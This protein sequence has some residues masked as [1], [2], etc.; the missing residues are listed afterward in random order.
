[1][2]LIQPAWAIVTSDQAG[3]HGVTAGQPAF[4]LNLDGVA[5]IGGLSA[6]EEPIAFCTGALISDRH[7]LCAA[8][9]FDVDGDGQFESLLEPFGIDE[10]VLFET[11][12][13]LV[14]I[15]YDIAAVQVPAGWP[16]QQAD[17]AVVTLA[18]NAPLDVDRYA[19][20]AGGDELGRVAVLTGY[21]TAGHGS[22]GEDIFLDPLP[23]KRAGLNR[24]D[25][26]DFL[27]E[28]SVS[29]IVADFDSGLTE[30][31]TLALFD[32]DSDL[33]FGDDEVGMASGDSGGPLFIGGAIAG[34][35]VFVAQPL[36]GDVND[37]PDA[38][39]GE[40]SGAVR[41]APFRD[42]IISATGGKAVF[43]PEPST[44]LLLFSGALGA[45]S[46]AKNSG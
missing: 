45:S 4:G 34:V 9:C 25:L 11:A 3:S 35:N 30:N 37:L 43:V 17:L 5:M 14:S 6:P 46:L 16:S 15:D 1:M 41:V 8:H 21:G 2:P 38:S 7:V 27:A 32:L 28:E 19:L 26:V 29:I 42:F 36:A 33:G 23:T 13:G 20:H 40:I 31:N 12:S 24:I 44:L 39:W 22:N 10:A 18:H